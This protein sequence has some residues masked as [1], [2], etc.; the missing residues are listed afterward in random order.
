MKAMRVAGIAVA[1]IIT[2]LA[3]M[4]RGAG[5]Q[6]MAERQFEFTFT[7]V[8]PQAKLDAA[9]LRLWIPLPRDTAWQK[10]SGLHINAP[11][12]YTRRRDPEYGN[13]YIYAEIPASRVAQGSTEVHVTFQTVRREERANL[14]GA[15]LGAPKSDSKDRL[16]LARYLQPDALVP[17]DGMLKELAEDQ[18]KG[19][20]TPLQRAKAIY[21]YVVNTMKYQ[22]TGEG[23]GRGD[24]VWACTSK[25]GNCTDFHSVFISMA[26]SVGI[27]ARFEIGFPLPEDKHDGIIPGYHCWGEFWAEPWGWI[28]VDASEAWKNPERRTYYFGALD[29]SRVMFTIGRDVPVEPAPAVGPLNYFIY[30]HAEVGG[31]AYTGIEKAF[32]FR[33][34]AAG[35]T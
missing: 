23:W 9:S 32:T 11:V 3:G 14:S 33:D 4:S 7:T 13:D 18:T 12:K 17:L 2:A 25:Y 28:P 34:L 16:M 1:I 20:T 5:T 29:A 26:R 6:P 24:A 15:D 27:P 35:K 31:T 19:L 22:K 10:I 30:P 8:V 21:D